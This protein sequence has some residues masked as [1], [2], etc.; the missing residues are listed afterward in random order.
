MKLFHSGSARLAGTGI[1]WLILASY[2][3]VAG[4]SE[5]VLEPREPYMLATPAFGLLSLFAALGLISGRPFV[6]GVVLFVAGLGLFGVV[7]TF[8]AFA[9]AGLPAIWLLQGLLAAV[10]VFFVWSLVLVVWLWPTRPAPR[11]AAA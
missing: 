1:V 2:L 10:G 7:A 8:I 9:R 3:L 6:R 4:T 5:W 11:P